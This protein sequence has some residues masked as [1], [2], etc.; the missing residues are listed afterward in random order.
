MTGDK[1]DN[2]WIGTEHGGLDCLNLKTGKFTHYPPGPDDGHHVI[3]ERITTLYRDNSG[4]LWIGTGGGLN[5]M[6]SKTGRLS[7]FSFADAHPRGRNDV[8][9]WSICED[10]RGT[11]WIGSAAKRVPIVTSVAQRSR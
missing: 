7:R 4:N 5:R 8:E 9:V 1:S 3:D 11:F 2:L 6:D 10:Y